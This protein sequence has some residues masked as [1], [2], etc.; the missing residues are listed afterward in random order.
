MNESHSWNE[1]TQPEGCGTRNSGTTLGRLL[2]QLG[3]RWGG[4]AAAE[5]A[6]NEYQENFVII[7]EA[8]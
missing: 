6:G 1:K 8:L 5:K 4:G 3:K 7:L 2:D